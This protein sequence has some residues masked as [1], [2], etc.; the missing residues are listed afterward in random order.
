MSAFINF[1]KSNWLFETVND[2]LNL[3][4]WNIFRINTCFLI[5]II[6]IFT[7]FFSYIFSIKRFL[8][9]FIYLILFSYKIFRIENCFFVDIIRIC[10]CLFCYVLCINLFFGWL[11]DLLS[12][13]CFIIE[14]F[15]LEEFFNVNWLHFWMAN[16]IICYFLFFINNLNYDFANGVLF[17]LRLL[18]SA[19]S[20]LFQLI[21]NFQPFQIS[22]AAIRFFLMPYSFFV[23]L[24]SILA[25]V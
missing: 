13:I 8:N 12:R 25:S 21:C 19:D 1:C 5:K 2:I 16:P 17:R 15:Y 7:C 11:F 9:I 3:F 20:S 14:A 18:G 23:N 10:T 6:R 24:F 22:I 4:S